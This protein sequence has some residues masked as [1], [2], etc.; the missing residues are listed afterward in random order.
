MSNKSRNNPPQPGQALTS[1]L[2]KFADAARERKAQLDEQDANTTPA[3]DLNILPLPTEQRVEKDRIVWTWLPWGEEISIQGVLYTR[4]IPLSYSKSEMQKKGDYVV[5]MYFAG[6]SLDPVHFF[7][8]C[9][10]LVGQALIS[11]WNYQH[12]WKQHAGDFIEMEVMKE[13][14]VKGEL[15]KID[16]TEA[17]APEQFHELRGDDHMVT[18]R[19]A[20]PPRKR[21]PRR[22]DG[23]DTRS[24]Q[25]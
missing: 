24:D 10:K 3:D 16:Q 14:P 7:G 25:V 8:D 20:S 12:I 18:K 9:A 22:T 1:F 17:I 15:A 11:A 5:H 13:E 2:T 23:E 4:D 6:D 19:P 21:K